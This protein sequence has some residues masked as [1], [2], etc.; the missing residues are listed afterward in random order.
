MSVI[1]TNFENKLNDTNIPFNK[2]EIE[3]G[4]ALYRLT[5]RLTT[6]RAL[7]VEVI[8]QQSEESYVDGQII[9]RNVHILNDPRKEATAYET[10]NRLNEMKTGYYSLFLAGDGEIFLKNLIRVGEDIEPLYQT[11]IMGS[12]IAKGLQKD[13]TD[14]LGETRKN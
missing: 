6:T 10:I 14:A 12:Q 7:V 1:Q 5:F 3:N 8:I 11:M 2:K 13:L 9:Y 4:H